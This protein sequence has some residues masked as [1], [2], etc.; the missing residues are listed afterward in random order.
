VAL[1]PD[2]R[3]LATAS[4]DRT[5]RIWDTTTGQTLTTLTG[6]TGPV[7]EV[8]FS[9][10]GR[11]LAT[12]SSDGTA[13]VW[14]AATG[15]TLTTLT[16]HTGE[17]RAVAFSIDRRRLATAG[18]DCTARIWD[19]GEDA[20][21]SLA[22]EAEAVAE[23]IASS[24]RAA[25]QGRA[26]AFLSYASA[27]GNIVLPVAEAVGALG[28][29]LVWDATVL[30]PGDQWRRSLRESLAAAQLHVFAVT[31]ASVESRFALQELAYSAG[32]GKRILPVIFQQVPSGE[33]PYELL[34]LQH[35]DLVD[36]PVEE[37][38]K[39]LKAAIDDMLE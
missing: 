12:A 16:G 3:R 15:Q 7:R 32:A 5:V 18:D 21:E 33:L 23:R 28:A 10:D 22:S 36:L 2:G 35:V 14:D 13:R 27:D 24:L 37:Q 20:L 38:A 29:G 1:S 26:D 30:Q 19:T 6:H 31:R 34:D 39:K 4:S 9:P 8:A 11:R 25:R 17:V